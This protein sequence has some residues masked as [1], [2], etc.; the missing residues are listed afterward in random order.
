M[1]WTFWI[2]AIALGVCVWGLL[3]LRKRLH[4]QKQAERLRTHLFLSE[5]ERTRQKKL[6]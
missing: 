1:A 4:K 2:G 3:L 6:K 5:L